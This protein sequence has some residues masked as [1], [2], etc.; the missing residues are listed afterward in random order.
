MRSRAAAAVPGAVECSATGPNRLQAHCCVQAQARR[1]VWR[2]QE[3]V[4][5]EQLV[6][7]VDKAT[8]SICSGSAGCSRSLQLQRQPR[9]DEEVPVGSQEG[10]GDLQRGTEGA[11]RQGRE[12]L[13][14]QVYEE[15]IRQ[16]RPGESC[17][18]R[19]CLEI[20]SETARER[21]DHFCST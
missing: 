5:G 6:G 7:F 8:Q 18:K 17:L 20:A 1:A 15:Q 3:S 4:A 16:H 13:C 19:E 21:S 2:D 11:E 10:R 12:V 14:H 9:R